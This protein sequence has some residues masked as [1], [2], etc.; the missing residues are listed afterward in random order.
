MFDRKVLKYIS[1][2]NI[3]E[4]A[5]ITSHN[6]KECNKERRR[7]PPTHCI[8]PGANLVPKSEEEC[9]ERILMANP[10]QEHRVKA[11]NKILVK[12]DFQNGKGGQ[13]A[14]HTVESS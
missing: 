1:S 13:L 7:H 10:T 14:L 3:S 2:T 5:N 12:R 9:V 11:I 4:N 8:K 6:K